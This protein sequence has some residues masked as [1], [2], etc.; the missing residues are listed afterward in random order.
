MENKQFRI[1]KPMKNG[2]GNAS[3]FE[4]VTKPRTRKGRDGND[5][6]FDQTMVFL[7]CAPQT[8]NDDSEFA[9]F[10]WNDENKRVTLKLGMPDITEMLCV[11]RGLKPTVGTV[12]PQGEKP[13]GLFHKNN[14][15]SA[16]LQFHVTEN[17]D[18]YF[19][20]AASKRGNDLVAVQHKITLSEG[21]SLRI[22]LEYAV[23]NMM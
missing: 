23:I 13:K 10:A 20:R 9:S 16:S 4:V 7:E 14:S 12:P 19:L 1:Y 11:L 2:A 18:G 5:V 22:L 17:G 3:K 8:N 6:T 21:E 15:G